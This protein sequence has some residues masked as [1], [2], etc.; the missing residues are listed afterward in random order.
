MSP[1]CSRARALIT[2]PAAPPPPH[3]TASTPLSDPTWGPSVSQV[4]YLD[5]SKTVMS[6]GSDVGPYSR[7]YHDCET[8]NLRFLEQ[9]SQYLTDCILNPRF[10]SF[11]RF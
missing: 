11:V 8:H 5:E 6:T 9:K 7:F 10:R 4:R 1:S 2:A 3:E